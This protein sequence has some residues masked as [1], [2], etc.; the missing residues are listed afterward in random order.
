M[1]QFYKTKLNEKHYIYACRRVCMYGQVGRQERDRIK[2]QVWRKIRKDKYSWLPYSKWSKK[3][4]R[5]LGKKGEK[6]YIHSYI[7]IY[8]DIEISIFKIKTIWKFKRSV[9]RRQLI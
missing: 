6:K 4:E 8:V 3:R 9:F 7:K 5:K 2:I 1:I